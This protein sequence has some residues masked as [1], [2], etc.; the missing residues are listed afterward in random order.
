MQG[1]LA[2]YIGIPANLF[3]GVLSHF[4]LKYILTVTKK[5]LCY[6]AKLQNCFTRLTPPNK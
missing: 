2:V 4:Y 3:W 5:L 6:N 1:V